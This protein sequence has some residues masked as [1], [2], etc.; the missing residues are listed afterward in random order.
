MKSRFIKEN[1]FC[2]GCNRRDNLNVHHI[3]PFHINRGLELDPS[4]LITLCENKT[5]NCHLWIGHL[6]NF[7]SYNVN[8]A[9][10]ADIIRQRITERP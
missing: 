4:N 9:N 1:N 6:G 8:V 5:L 10:D 7:V 2:R 3:V